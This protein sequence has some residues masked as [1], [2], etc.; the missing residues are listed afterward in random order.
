[1]TYTDLLRELAVLTHSARQRRMV[2]FGRLA[3]GDPDVRDVLTQLAIGGVTERGLALQACY[4]S[5][6]GEAVL[7]SLADPSRLIRGLA[8]VLVAEVCDD[9][10]VDR[11]INTISNAASRGRLLR[12]LSRRHRRVIVDRWLTR[13]MGDGDRLAG[14]LLSYGSSSFV[15]QQLELAAQKG[16]TNSNWYRLARYHSDAAITVLRRRAEEVSQRDAFLV[17]ISQSMLAELADRRPD[18]TLGLV[19]VLSRHVSLAELPL[20]RLIDRRPRELA[21]LILATPDN[22]R[23]DFTRVAERLDETRLTALLSHR[24]HL[25]PLDERWFRRIA[26]VTR[27]VLFPH[28]QGRRDSDG[29]LPAWLLERLCR[30]NRRREARAHWHHL[31]LAARPANRFPYASCLPW[32]E[33]RQALDPFIRNPDAVLRAAAISALVRCVKF[34]RDRAAELLGF[35]LARKNEQDPVRCSILSALADLPTGVW[36][37]EQLDDLGKV[38]RQA[39]DATDLSFATAASAQRLV[40]K[41]LP[42][43]PTWA[44]G[45]LATLVKERGRVELG[46]LEDKLTDADIQRLAPTLLP[47]LRAWDTRERQSQLISAA[48]SLGRRLRVF[49][50]FIAI[51]EGLALNATG[52]IASFALAALQQHCPSRFGPLVPRLLDNDPSW[53]TQPLVYNHVHRRRQDLLV[54]FLGRQAYRGRFSTGKTRFVLSVA[55]GFHRWWP[56]QRTVFA[57]TL[58]EVTRDR[59][60]DNPAL[61]HIISQ[62]AAVIDVPAATERLIELADA[63]NEKLV[64]RDAA[65]RALGRLD[66]SQGVPTLID[67]LNDDRGRIAIY[68]LRRALLDQPPSQALLQLRQV[69][70]QKVTVAKEVVRLIGDLRTLDAY[71]ELLAWNER[72][73][74]R[75]VRVAL[76]RALWEFLDR[77]QTWPILEQAAVSADPAIATSVSRVPAEA[78]SH[79]NQQRLA[80]LIALVLSHPDPQVRSDGLSRCATLPVT[81]DERALLPPLLGALKSAIASEVQLA[82]SAVFATYVGR[83][84]AAVGQ[85]LMELLPHRQSLDTTLR[86]FDTQLARDRIRLRPTLDV[87]LDVLEIDPLCVT[88]RVRLAI[89]GLRGEELAAYFEKL[90]PDLHAEALM[91]AANELSSNGTQQFIGAFRYVPVPTVSDDWQAFETRLAAHS[92]ERLRRIAFAALIAQSQQSSGWTEA[93]RARLETYRADPS[94][95]VASAAAF[96]FPP[97]IPI[98]VEAVGFSPDRDDEE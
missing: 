4:G 5:R 74:H 42:A 31:P 40:V 62:L 80:R 58:D 17:S 9:E 63:G 96:T 95:L 70:Q 2:E 50:E 94:R 33:A 78:L 65:L 98:A 83:G 67:A 47:V 84:A 8:M 24:P 89:G 25:L 6:D 10:Q 29:C 73:L 79:H 72:D 16:L 22:V 38:L 46:R 77:D 23:G 56:T 7:R 75:D 51:L 3:A 39:L 32:D 48:A 19:R 90:A 66:A 28:L 76:L 11:A 57:S 36:R 49:P 68:A 13:L 30:E 1:M 14:S 92:D 60:R 45:W 93:L 35:V 37:A 59:G 20:Q 21:D 97:P 55:S 12:R 52:G 64:T 34:E 86:T 41:L 54:P 27:T 69:P 87:A 44:I 43:H 91:T 15:E 61:L 71:A 18:A 81:D 53:I 26:P 88:W 82:A 85:A